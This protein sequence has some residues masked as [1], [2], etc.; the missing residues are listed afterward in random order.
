MANQLDWLYGVD[1]DDIDALLRNLPMM[2]VM[3]QWMTVEEAIEVW[4]YR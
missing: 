4:N 1:T 3:S 2:W